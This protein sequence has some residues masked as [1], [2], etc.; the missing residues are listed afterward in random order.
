MDKLKG[1]PLNEVLKSSAKE[2]AVLPRELGFV[3]ENFFEMVSADDRERLEKRF[4]L[5]AEALNDALAAEKEEAGRDLEKEEIIFIAKSFF[6][7]KSKPIL[8]ILEKE[9]PGES[10]GSVKKKKYKKGEIE[11]LKRSQAL[12]DHTI[13]KL[14]NTPGHGAYDLHAETEEESAKIFAE[15]TRL[16]WDKLFVHGMV[17]KD[18]KGNNTIKAIADLDGKS[19]LL[20]LKEAGIDTRNVTYTDHEEEPREEGLHMDYSA[21]K[22]TGIESRENGK[23]VIDD[24]HG[25]GATRNTSATKFLYEALV[26]I[27]LLPKN[28]AYDKYVDFVTTEDNKTYY[29][30]DLEK[31]FKVYWKRLQGL[32]NYMQPEDIW[33]LFREGKNVDVR[34]DDEYLKN[35]FSIHPETKEKKPLKEISDK[36]KGMVDQAKKA[37][38]RLEKEGFFVD[39]GKEHY[40]KVLIDIARKNPKTGTFSKQVYM[41][42][43]AVRALGYDGYVVWSPEE[44]SFV[45]YTTRPMDFTLS[46]GFSVRE[47][48]NN[49]WM[50]P[51]G[52]GEHLTITLREI[53]EKLSGGK[54]ETGGKLKEYLEEEEREAKETEFVDDKKAEADTETFPTEEE[55]RKK[56]P[57]GNIFP[58]KNGKGNV[59]VAKYDPATGLVT[60]YFIDTVSGK[61]DE[62]EYSFPDFEKMMAEEVE[63]KQEFSQ[64]EQAEFDEFLNEAREYREEVAGGFD[65]ESEGYDEDEKKRALDL[66]T[67][68]YIKKLLKDS[69]DHF[70]KNGKAIALKII[71]KI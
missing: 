21:R 63:E 54:F 62:K 64:E 6:R 13:Y 55:F 19:C 17:V 67:E 2:A 32:V 12:A 22:V 30:S 71:D 1:T 68:V 50:K 44:K 59:S 52:N 49:M 40:Q 41:G 7:E 51:R 45:I 39:T 3:R 31:A 43:D 60:C 47:S 57:D 11:R 24:H 36:L 29:K 18:G 66:M 9:F 23:I 53:L 70:K 58:R 65:W 38:S 16:L 37:V 15:K 46:Q 8:D 33:N 61:E 48:S 56:Y 5:W 42:N 34:L 27:G 35:H 4:N 14:E 25:E 20:L 28:E 26:D 69:S 10:S